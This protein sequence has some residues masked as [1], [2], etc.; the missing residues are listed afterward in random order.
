MAKDFSELEKEQ[1]NTYLPI[2][3]VTKL[4]QR[5]ANRRWSLARTITD[6]LCRG[7]NVDPSEYGIEDG[8]ESVA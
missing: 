4:R 8:K 7:T 1:V 2:K 6:A 3:L 5:A